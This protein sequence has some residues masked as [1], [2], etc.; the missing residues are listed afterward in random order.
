VIHADGRFRVRRRRQYRAVP[1]LFDDIRRNHGFVDV[2]GNP[3]LAAAIIEGDASPALR[4][5]LVS[6]AAT[7]S[8]LLTLGCDLGEHERP[9]THQSVRYATGGYIQWLFNPPE[10]H[11]PEQYESLAEALA[12]ELDPLSGLHLGNFLHHEVR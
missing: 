1:S 5:L 4:S 3:G 11:N 12:R 10:F 9:D 2:R 6:L 7:G 8:P